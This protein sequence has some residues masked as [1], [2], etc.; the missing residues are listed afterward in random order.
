MTGERKVSGFFVFLVVATAVMLAAVLRPVATALLLATVL[1]TVTWPVRSWLTRHLRGHRNLAAGLLTS[2]AV[3][4]MVGPLAAFLTLVVR[5]GSDGL[6]F[7][8]DTAHSERVATLV[9]SMPDAMRDVATDAIDH[10]PRDLGEALGL[11]GAH[12]DRASA[13]AAVAATGAFVFNS[14]MMFIALFFLL[15]RGDDLVAWLDNISPLRSGQTREL[16]AAVRRV[17]H[18]VITSTVITAAVQTAVALVGYLIAQV[19]NPVFFGTTTFLVA[20]IPAIGAAS[21]CVVAALLLLATGHAFMAGFLAVWGVAVVGLIDNVIKPLLVK[22]GME[23][24]GGV[25]FFALIGGLA[26]FG[27]IGLVIG[28]LSLS[29]FLALLRMYHRDFSPEE[30]RLPPVPGLRGDE[31][32]AAGSPIA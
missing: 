4:L 8:A 24:H 26:A 1:A 3:L 15:A 29:L 25:V 7:V 13:A 31:S 22:G 10:L 9:A 20:F 11:V 17:S 16:F 28:P 12:S 30:T 2:A 21:V 27:A 19:P 6:R 23:L 5:D 18:A 14:V 32:S